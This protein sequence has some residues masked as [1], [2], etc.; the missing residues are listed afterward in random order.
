LTTGAFQQ[1]Q[2]AAAHPA[3]VQASQ[4]AAMLA[5]QAALHSHQS[6]QQ[7]AALQARVEQHTYTIQQAMPVASDSSTPR[8]R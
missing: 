7:Q 1:Q 2:T 6:N 8:V 4:Q 3:G 5:A